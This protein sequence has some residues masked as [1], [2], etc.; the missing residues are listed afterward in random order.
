LGEGGSS[1]GMSGDAFQV[2]FVTGAF[3]NPGG[4]VGMDMPFIVTTWE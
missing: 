4:A 1:E 2:E 3:E